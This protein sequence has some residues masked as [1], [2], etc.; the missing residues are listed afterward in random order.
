MLDQALCEKIHE[1]PDPRR[2]VR[3]AHKNGM[4]CFDVARI[5]VFQYRHQLA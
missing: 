2:Y 4:D 1:N 5:I 3:P